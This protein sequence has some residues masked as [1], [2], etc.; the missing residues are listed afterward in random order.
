MGLNAALRWSVSACKMAWCKAAQVSSDLICDPITCPEAAAALQL[1]ATSR[2]TQSK[3]KPAA[4]K[5][6]VRNHDP[7]GNRGSTKVIDRCRALPCNVTMLPCDAACLATLPCDARKSLR[8]ARHLEAMTCNDSAA[9]ASRVAPH[10]GPICGD[11]RAR[12]PLAHPTESLQVASRHP[13]TRW[14]GGQTNLPRRNVPGA[15]ARQRA[16]A[17]ARSPNWLVHR[18]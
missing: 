7:R 8:T 9:G 15:R 1:P 18:R 17:C 11:A 3:P 10:P 13:G 5:R 2:S 12:V 6:K 16:R 14:R 4:S